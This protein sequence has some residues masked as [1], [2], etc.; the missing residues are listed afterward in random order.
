MEYT[1]V[2]DPDTLVVIG[3]KTRDQLSIGDV[4]AL[5]YVFLRRGDQLYFQRRSPNKELWPGILDI[6]AGGLARVE[7]SFSEA[8]S[9]E[10]K[11]ELGI[12]ITPDRLEAQKLWTGIIICDDRPC[13]CHFY[14]GEAGEADEPV[15]DG[16]EVTGGIWLTLSEFE[17]TQRQ[18]RDA[19]TKMVYLALERLDGASIRLW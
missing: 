8:A 11:E 9:R 14:L 3:T 2:Y 12:L 7:E 6:S 4:R 13:Y 18:N 17:T 16:V 15:V 5:V 19:F 10:L 1:H